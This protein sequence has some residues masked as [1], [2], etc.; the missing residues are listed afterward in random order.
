M[1]IAAVATIKHAFDHGDW[2]Y[3][4]KLVDGLGNT[5]NGMA[6]VEWF[7]L[8]GGLTLDDKGFTGWSGKQHIED[9]F[10]AAKDTMWWELKKANPFKGYSLEAQLQQL[11]KNHNAIV[12]KAED[13][14]EV[15]KAKIDVKVNDATI[16]AVLQ[17]CNFDAIIGG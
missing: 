5:V 12:K 11:I 15:D 1:Q 16:Q 7:K 10:Q 14:D 6:L 13:M 8:Y 9:N 17:L 4:Q 2:T 3:A